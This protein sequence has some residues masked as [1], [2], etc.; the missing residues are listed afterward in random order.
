[1]YENKSFEINN[2]ETTNEEY[3]YNPNFLH[4]YLNNLS[5]QTI[6]LFPTNELLSKLESKDDLK[7]KIF[8]ITQE[9][10]T[11]KI[12]KARRQSN[13]T[14]IKIFSSSS[15]SV[16]NEKNEEEYFEI[17]DF[18]SKLFCAI[19]SNCSFEVGFMDDFVN[20][21]FFCLTEINFTK[22][23]FESGDI[24]VLEQCDYPFLQRLTFSLCE[25]DFVQIDDIFNLNIEN[26][27]ELL[28]DP[29]QQAEPIE[30]D[31]LE[32]AMKGTLVSQ[33]VYLRFSAFKWEKAHYEI[34]FKTFFFN[35][36]TLI[37]DYSD[38]N[39][40]CVDYFLEN[41]NPFEKFG[42]LECFEFSCSSRDIYRKFAG[43]PLAQIK[44]ISFKCLEELYEIATSSNFK[45]LESIDLQR[46]KF[47][48][49][50]EKSFKVWFELAQGYFP[51]LKKV[52]FNKE[53]SGED[54]VNLV[55]SNTINLERITFNQNANLGKKGMEALVSCGWDI[56][57]LNLISCKLGDEEFEILF[58]GELNQINKIS[59]VDNL[60]GE[61]GLFQF[62]TNENLRSNLEYLVLESNGLKDNF[63]KILV[64]NKFYNLKSFVIREN[65]DVSC[66]LKVKLDEVYGNVLDFN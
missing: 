22:C 32:I 38:L 28:I 51:C 20:T 60:I 48:N 57:E 34:I 26:L 9:F 14:T 40:T 63:V 58:A 19:F 66:A 8:L 56:Q 30:I 52:F 39:E 21:N 4:N 6:N 18:Q 12:E 49:N 65:K 45:S 47:N 41:L 2:N 36:K 24:R 27:T 46:I 3:I 42:K 44:Q 37:L 33:L 62:C 10:F 50:E 29:M 59:I 1:M 25:L 55:N 53:F 5:K 17:E 35:L 23:V 15:F 11:K 64:E 31:F 7:T 13:Q 43:A 54:L 61:K 16:D